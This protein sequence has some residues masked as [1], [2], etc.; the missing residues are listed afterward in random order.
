M[1]PR[2]TQ[3]P[4]SVVSL[5][6]VKLCTHPQQV[7]LFMSKLIELEWFMQAPQPPLKVQCHS[8]LAEILRNVVPRLI[9][10]RRPTF[11]TKSITGE[12]KLE[13]D[14]PVIIPQFSTAKDLEALEHTWCRSFILVHHHE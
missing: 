3:T 12:E 14:Y 2:I 8:N 11:W 4:A 7:F 10:E 5:N 9:I 1:F 6:D 13:H